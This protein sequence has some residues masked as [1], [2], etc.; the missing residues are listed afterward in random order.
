MG[1]SLF[2]NGYMHSLACVIVILTKTSICQSELLKNMS[3]NFKI[4]VKSCKIYRG[5]NTHFKNIN[6]LSAKKNC[7]NIFNSYKQSLIHARC[8]KKG[9][10]FRSQITGKLLYYLTTLNALNYSLSTEFSL[11]VL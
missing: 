9:R 1:A 10:P 11:H 8:I 2:E 7:G 6:I 3:K 4:F 5:S